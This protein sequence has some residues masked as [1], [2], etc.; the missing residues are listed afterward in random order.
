MSYSEER[1]RSIHDR[2]AGR[3]HLCHET[4]DVGG[5]PDQWEVDH[6]TPRARGGKDSY[7]NLYPAH[8]HCNRKRQDRPASL[9]RKEHGVS[10][11]PLSRRE[12]QRREGAFVLGAA[13][14]LIGVSAAGLPEAIGIAMVGAILG[15]LIG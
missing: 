2:T 5:Y 3:C 15:Y 11:L 14:L 7:E 8:P 10:G 9:V 13:K 6:L 4:I 12:L 1:L